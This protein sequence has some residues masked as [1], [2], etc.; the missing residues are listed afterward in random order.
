MQDNYDYMDDIFENKLVSDIMMFKNEKRSSNL[1]GS[2][3]SLDKGNGPL[4]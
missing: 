2:L 3:G 4:Y 1:I